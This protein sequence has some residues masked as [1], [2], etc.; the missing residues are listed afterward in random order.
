MPAQ[1]E[2]DTVP[3]LFRRL[4]IRYRG[5]ERPVLRHKERG[6]GWH[7]ITWEDLEDRVQALAG[8][9]HQCGIR[10]GD[11]VAL[12]SE[13]RPEWAITDL[14]TQLI[15]AANVSIYTSLPPSKIAYILRDA[16]ATACVVSVPV[17]RKK[18]EEIADECPD[19][20]EVIVMS[21]LPDDPPSY[22]THWEDALAAGRDYWNENEAPLTAL[23]DDITPDDI[24]ALIYT[25]GTTGQP[26]GVVLTNRNFCSNV[27]AAL[28]RVPFGEDDHH[29]SF[30]PLSH[31][32]ERTA[33]HTAVLA[34]GAT[35][36]YAE[37][38]EAVSQN[39]KEVQP[40]I[41]I[42]VPRMFEKVYNRVTKQVSEGGA[43]K[44]NLFEWAVRTGKKH[45]EAE[46]GDG[47]GPGPWLKTQQAL[48][49]RLVFSTLHEKLGGNLKFAVSGGAALPK[50]IGTFFQAAGVTIIEGYGLTETAPV[51]SVNPL[52]APRYGTVGHILPGVSVAIQSLEGDKR[53]GEVNGNEYP[54]RTT[55]EEGEILVKG[56]NV[57][58]EYWEDPEQ[59]R[60]AFDPDGWY[61]TGDVGRFENGYLQITDRIKHMIVSRGGKN[62]YPGPIE[63]TF[64]TQ[65]WIDQIVV[66]G[67]DRPFLSA[68]VVPD[69]ESLRM[70]ARDHDIDEGRYDDEELLEHEDVRS[71]FQQTFRDFNRDAAAHEKIRNF[72][73]LVEPFTVED[74]TL[75]P[76]L[77]LRRS[78]I[79]DRYSDLV[80]EMYE[81]FGQ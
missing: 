8:Y 71:L 24:S 9:L 81:E 1:V 45:A 26:K 76:T 53:I 59:T 54:T 15:G 69:F 36:S 73:L 40:T 58:R 67:E 27:K 78:V 4:C 50:E 68:L 55:T 80:D 19:L 48:A 31:A 11:R 63:E 14:G 21:E 3:Q 75:T 56:P 25:S 61:H 17:Q 44:Q 12:L 34:A 22:M 7:E 43:V 60:A 49:Q 5:Q 42:S 79:R 30:L 70:R 20:E 6:D 29:L 13:N 74:G 57:M 64:K 39:L 41:M 72:R 62:I 66:I 28:Q 47:S 52:D 35:I 18:I 46:Q 65:A 16:G 37:S 23:A 32:F 10:K 51:I 38:V 2:F 77:K 33:G